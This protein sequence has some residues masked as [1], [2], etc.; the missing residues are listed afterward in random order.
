[1]IT[2]SAAIVICLGTWLQRLPLRFISDPTLSAVA[3]C[4]VQIKG[5][6]LPFEICLL[7]GLHDCR[8]EEWQECVRVLN[9]PFLENHLCARKYLCFTPGLYD[10][11]CHLHSLR[12]R[13]PWFL[14]SP[15]W[16]FKELL[17]LLIGSSDKSIGYC[18]IRWMAWYVTLR[19]SRGTSWFHAGKHY[20][21]WQTFIYSLLCL[22]CYSKACPEFSSFCLR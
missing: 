19:T 3:G 5:L 18:G 21:P 7:S 12:P 10:W 16:L 22:L 1:M 20:R 4:S 13:W 17:I 6:T 8:E 14:I 2:S 15:P 9:L 11:I